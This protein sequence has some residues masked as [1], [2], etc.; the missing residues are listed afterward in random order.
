MNLQTL[1][2]AIRS[3]VRSPGYT[4]AF[5]LTL[6]L[7]IGANTAIFSVLNAVLL[8]PLPHADGEQ[9]VYLRQTAQ[10]SGIEN[11]TFSVPEIEDI[12]QQATTLDGVAEFSSMTFTMVSGLEPRRV[13]TGVVTANYFDVAGLRP[14]LGRLMAAEENSDSAASVMVLTDRF[15]QQFFGGDEE[16][17]GRTVELSG[18]AV[19]IIGVLEPAPPYPERTDVFVNMVTSPHHMSASM[20]SDRLHRMTEVFARRTA[21]L[22]QVKAEVGAIAA[23]LYQEY[24]EAY[25]PAHGYT[26]SVTPLRQQLAQR[27][28]P[29]LL[30]LL[31]ASVFVLLVACANVAN[32]TLARIARRQTELGVRAALGAGR[33][34]LR[35]QLLVENL[36]PALAGG[37]L[38]LGIAF[39]GLDV[40]VAYASRFS[41]RAS[42]IA[43]DGRVFLVALTFSVVAACFFAMIPR[44]PTEA[45]A[46]N[47]ASRTATS[48]GGRRLQGLL[49]ASQ[50]AVSFV[51]LMGA[52]LLLR[53]VLHLDA[54]DTGLET[55]KVLS[56][57]IPGFGARRDP[58][59]RFSQIQTLLQQVSELPG[60]RS[61]GLSN[62]VPLRVQEGT[63]RGQFEYQVE[64]IANDPSLPPPRA[65]SRSVSPAYIDTV[66]MRVLSGR[67]FDDRDGPDG[68]KVAVISESLAKRHFGGR[69]PVGQRIAWSGEI[70]RFIGVS[71]E[72]RRI[73]GV[74]TDVRD[75]GPSQE[76]ADIVFQPISQQPAVSAL[77]VRAEQSPQTLSQPV[78]DIIRGLA[79]DQPIENVA[80]LEQVRT[81]SFA[82]QR[83]N[84]T[85]LGIFALLALAIAAVG[86]AGVLSFSVSSRER[87][88]GIRA[89]LG[90]ERSRL[91]R[92]IVREGVALAG[93]GLVVGVAGAVALTRFMQG[94]LFG[95]EPNDPLTFVGVGL[96]LSIVTIGASLLPAWR[97][98]R[99]DPAT[100]LRSE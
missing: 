72:W 66:G 87:E 99:T 79:A 94:L 75:Y 7:G 86:V 67:F 63:R 34:V 33:N 58:G 29:T 92:G 47:A 21:P 2:F 96:V 11:V 31:G 10:L 55:D 61:A 12:R 4:L 6:G 59:E 24:P 100:V 53:S 56:V 76:A 49:V 95:V 84:S 3:L 93:L 23:R 18:R 35:R 82:P 15:W 19:T 50:I 54:V 40:L 77:F 52:G 38:A 45:G 78:V 27:A 57:E 70:L 43:L 80:T 83:L 88:L 65:D 25:D 1:R 97:A 85:L 73:V 9:I 14:I 89:A 91:L 42:E 20:S 46:V 69:D 30:I 81:E 90:A 62:D 8:R 28:R 5:I 74:V 44:L 13:R 51:L 39:V 22:E 60:V 48:A 71:D 98:A 37:V 68:D 36:L 26:V 16:V 17:V 41:V 64:G 32:L